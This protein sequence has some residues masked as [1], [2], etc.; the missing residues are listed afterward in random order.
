MNDS[1]KIAEI[2]KLGWE[3]TIQWILDG[4]DIDE[5]ETFVK[6]SIYSAIDND[7]LDSAINWLRFQLK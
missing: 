1:V 7:G 5:A 4:W 2:N 3:V 6:S